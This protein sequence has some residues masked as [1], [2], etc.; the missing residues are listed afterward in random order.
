MISQ[1][2]YIYYYTEYISEQ[3][4]PLLKRTS[5]NEDILVIDH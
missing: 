4:D 2:I 1:G 3:I 5:I